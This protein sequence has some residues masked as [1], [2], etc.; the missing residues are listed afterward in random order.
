MCSFNSI[1]SYNQYSSSVRPHNNNNYHNTFLDSEPRTC[2]TTADSYPHF[3]S[4]NITL[5]DN[6]YFSYRHSF[7]ELL[8]LNYLGGIALYDSVSVSSDN[9]TTIDLISARLLTIPSTPPVAAMAYFNDEFNYNCS[10]SREKAEDRLTA[11]VFTSAMNVIFNQLIEFVDVDGDQTYTPGIDHVVQSHDLSKQSWDIICESPENEE[12]NGL[13][14]YNSTTIKPLDSVDLTDYVDMSIQLMLT[15]VLGAVDGYV[16]TPRSGI[17]EFQV[18]NYPY[19]GYY[20]TTTNKTTQ[21]TYLAL[22]TYVISGSYNDTESW[23]VNV[24]TGDV[25][26]ITSLH[27][28]AVN[29]SDADIYLNWKSSVEVEHSATQDNGDIIVSTGTA[30]MKYSVSD[31]NDAMPGLSGELYFGSTSSVQV[32]KKLVYYSIT[33]PRPSSIHSSYTLG[34]GK[35]ANEASNIISSK[36]IAIVGVFALACAGLGIGWFVYR[37]F[38]ESN[39]REQDLID[40]DAYQRLP[41]EA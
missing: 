31:T 22:E 10:S 20:N 17:I 5:I 25:S 7:S 9:T 11:G 33:T 18:N 3:T 19:L 38:S 1:P 28:I 21:D 12:M 26:E 37:S 41:S 13:K 4:E 39:K 30:D 16:I 24:E 15:S 35:S 8:T 14:V 40:A 29:N 23:S 27:G 6:A 32:S 36:N 34:V 2:S